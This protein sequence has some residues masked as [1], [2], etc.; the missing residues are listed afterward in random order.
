MLG[1]G[2]VATLIPLAALWLTSRVLSHWASLS[3]GWA[4]GGLCLGLLAALP[5]ARRVRGLPTALA[6]FSVSL[7]GLAWPPAPAGRLAQPGPALQRFEATVLQSACGEEDC[8]HLVEVDRGGGTFGQ[9]LPPT[10]RLSLRG[11]RPLAVGGRYAMLAR[12]GPRPRFLNPSPAPT[13]P[14]QA[15]ALQGRL[16]AQARPLEPGW[17]W[18]QGIRQ[19]LR[20]GLKQTLSPTASGVARALL[21]GES[22]ATPQALGN[23]V[24]AAGVAHLLAVSGLHITLLAGAFAWTVG[25]IFRRTPWCALWDARR[26]RALA[27]CLLCPVVCMVC[28]AGPS[29]LRAATT[30]CIA[31]ALTA[32][33][34]QPRS[35]QVL[36][37]AVLLLGAL[38]PECATRAGFWLSVAATSALLGGSNRGGLVGALRTSGRTWLATAP[39]VLWCFGQLAWVGVFSN[40]VLLP[41]GALLLIP[42][43][44]LHGA[45]ASLCPTLA[46]PSA[47]LFETLCAGFGTLCGLFAS[48]F[49]Q[50]QPSPLTAVQVAALGL[51]TFALWLRSPR[52]RGACVAVAT[53]VFGLA[54]WHVRQP[55]PGLAVHFL[56]VGQGDAALLRT[57][58]GQ[59]MLIDGGGAVTGGP[60][61]GQRVVV[62]LLRA[63]RIER[64]DVVVITHGHPDHYGGMRA[65]FESVEVGELWLSGQLLRE[66]P[67]GPFAS[68]VGEQQRRGVR[69]RQA[70]QLC[71]LDRPWRGLDVRVLGPCP[72]PD[73]GYGLNDNSLVLQVLFGERRWLF[74]GDIEAQG[75]DA[76]RRR[77]PTLRADVLKVGHHGSRTSSAEALL[78][79]LRPELA[80]ISAGRHN[81]FGHPHGEVTE[82]LARLS[83]R[84]F[85]TDQHGGVLVESDGRNLKATTGL[86]PGRSAW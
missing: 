14:H 16:M 74:T 60:D 71:N 33:G 19:T 55:P 12:V 22:R 78:R 72:G 28:G 76:L 11:P 36:A 38:Q 66:D 75:E 13:W 39:V 9:Q 17:H 82:R 27:G 84:V 58:A 70:E 54:E 45:V 53:L 24:R 32:T 69:V 79:Q 56:D 83:G 5:Q 29:A 10:T 86:S 68:W 21:L 31:W 35:G 59:S 85:R 65:V 20:R 25:W 37:A 73:S 41:F 8:R 23:Q 43:A 52:W 57:P 63:H 1:A 6:L 46:S 44:A 80:V 48:A 64:L 15:P 30:C 62:P 42:A 34:R 77:H 2:S 61:P 49:P 4:A 26:V 50:W 7:A 40:L 18:L 47:W 67:E 3:I 81:T 51:C